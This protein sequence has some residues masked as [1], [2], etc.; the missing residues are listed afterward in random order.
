[1]PKRSPHVGQIFEDGFVSKGPD[2]LF[3]TSGMVA[4]RRCYAGCVKRIA[5]VLACTAASCGLL[6][7]LDDLASGDAGAPDAAIDVPVV[8]GEPPPRPDG[9]VP[10]SL[11]QTF[12][13]RTLDI[14]DVDRDGGSSAQ[15]WQ[16]FGYNLD[17]KA[18][19]AGS[20][21]VC[22]PVSGASANVQVDG[23]AGIDNSWGENLLPLLRD[24]NSDGYSSAL[25]S[26][27]ISAGAWTLLI[28]IDGLGNDPSQTAV[29]LTAQVF[30]GAALSSTPTFDTSTVWPVLSSSLVD[31]A[32]FASGATVRF[33]AAYVNGG[34]FVSGATSGVLVVHLLSQGYAY[35]LFIHHAI[36]TFDHISPD[37]GAHGTIAGVLDTQELLATTKFVASI[38]DKSLCSG[39]AI[40]SILDQ[41]AQ[42][43]DMYSD[44]T[45]A[46]NGSC[47]GIS[48]GLGFEAR[49]IANPTTVTTAPAP[50]PDP[51]A[52]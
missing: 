5:L 50:P 11:V 14:G 22:A 49:V 26:Q 35:P 52:D 34:T 21:D 30:A 1:M 23:V 18:T 27:L 45:N 32:T 42:T 28:Q 29:G 2:A 51:C 31:N 37:V 3:T 39:P 13:I 47:T 41:I 10:A 33:D 24:I 9:G 15:A 19:T 25:A 46:A 48:I 16:A 20:T 38:L 43:S 36:I 12:A 6:T 4:E 40:Q 17:A 7:N 44:G 8:P